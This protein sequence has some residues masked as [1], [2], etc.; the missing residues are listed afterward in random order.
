MKSFG[1]N[2]YNIL[3]ESI[4]QLL[5]DSMCSLTK[6]R[7]TWNMI[8]FAS[9]VY[10]AKSIAFNTSLTY[11]DVSYNGLGV[12]G[13]EALG[14]AISYNKSLIILNVA[15]NNLTPRAAFTMLSGIRTCT[16]FF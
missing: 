1:Y 11:L 4:G 10:L 6:L 3:G 8:R 2:N 16:K 9:G 5:E 14:E 13:G 15:H 12:A 7:V